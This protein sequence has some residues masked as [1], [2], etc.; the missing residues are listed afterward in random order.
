MP[1]S[2]TG[3]YKDALVAL[4]WLTHGMLVGFKGIHR[5]LLQHIVGCITYYARPYWH[6]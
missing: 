2:P 3:N 4:T 1:I 6:V 5:A